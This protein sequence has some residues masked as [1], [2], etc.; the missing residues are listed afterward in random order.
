MDPLSVAGSIVGILTAAAKVVEIVEPFISSTKDA[1]KIAVSV[2]REV[3]RVRMVL[4]SLQDILNGLSASPKRAAFIQVDQ[5]VVTFTDGVLI[6]SELET[7][8]APLMMPDQAQLPLVQRFQWASKK[9]VIYDVLQRLQGFLISLSA[10]L[11]IFQCASDIAASQ[12]QRGFD[13]QVSKVLENNQA[14]AARVRG[15]EDA[16]DAKSTIRGQHGRVFEASTE[17]EDDATISSA[18]FQNAQFHSVDE[19]DGQQESIALA[20]AAT[21]SRFNALNFFGFEKELITSRVYKRAKRLESLYSLSSSATGSRTWTC[22]SGLSLADIS[23]ISVIALPLF[24]TDIRNAHHYCFGAIQEEKNLEST[25]IPD[26]WVESDIPAESIACR[27]PWFF[28]THTCLTGFD[29]ERTWREHETRMHETLEIWPCE[30]HDCTK[31][32]DSDKDMMHHYERD[33]SQLHVPRVQPKRVLPR[34]VFGCGFQYCNALLRGWRDRCDHM[35]FHMK[36]GESISEWRYSNVIRN[37]LQQDETRDL[38]L[39]L[40]YDL[41]EHT[42]EHQSRFQWLLGNTLILKLKL[43]CCDF[44]PSPE[45][46]AVAALMLRSDLPIEGTDLKVH[47][48]LILP[49]FDT[50]PSSLLNPSISSTEALGRFLNSRWAYNSQPRYGLA[51]KQTREATTK[52]AEEIKIRNQTEL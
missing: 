15:L 28:C 17:E 10:M 29:N 1:P 46:V 30:V 12:S 51:V 6:F 19:V 48:G 20:V 50:I 21:G 18:R 2:H 38:W 27:D 8:L 32:F 25:R 33:H 7:I 39:A 3:N 34:K 13:A 26:E 49:T 42:R 44:R 40:I 45:D 47:G 35:A 23:A 16:F 4:S 36:R 41:P 52:K 11:N 14:L 37:L 31:I 5:L 22:F 43:E 24:Q 9:R